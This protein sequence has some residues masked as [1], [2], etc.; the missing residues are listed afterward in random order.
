MSEENS[1]KSIKEMLKKIDKK[2]EELDRPETRKEVG[3]LFFQKAYILFTLSNANDEET[4]TKREIG[5]ALYQAA[6]RYHIA[7]EDE[8]L[9]TL[10]QFVRENKLEDSHPRLKWQIERIISQKPDIFDTMAAPFPFDLSISK[11]GPTSGEELDAIDQKI[12][13]RSIIKEIKKKIKEIGIKEENGNISR[14]EAAK[15]YERLFIETIDLLKEHDK[16]N[17]EIKELAKEIGNRCL[18]RSLVMQE[19][20]TATKILTLAKE[21]DIPLHLHYRLKIE[22]MSKILQIFRARQRMVWWIPI[23]ELPS[24][25]EVSDQVLAVM[26]R[27]F[28]LNIEENIEIEITE[29]YRIDLVRGVSKIS[30]EEIIGD[31]PRVT[32]T[33]VIINLHDF[34]PEDLLAVFYRTKDIEGL[35]IVPT[36][37]IQRLH[38]IHLEA[39]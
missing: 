4:I 36:G 25:S 18:L 5:T 33:S 37:E 8:L 9:A 38:I 11:L 16:S 12:K 2:I 22:K 20:E 14:L 39:T 31:L 6:L 7:E 34:F 27:G 30:V 23:D 32:P 3:D 35:M 1:I 17:K 19:I 13:L 24:G 28:P 29:I 21:H 10:L 15:E 26:E